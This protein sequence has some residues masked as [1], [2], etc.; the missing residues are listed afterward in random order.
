MLVG[1]LQ[2][3]ETY[4]KKDFSHSKVRWVRCRMLFISHPPPGCWPVCF[5]FRTPLLDAGPYVFFFAGQMRKRIFRIFD[6]SRFFR[7]TP[8][9][10]NLAHQMRKR[11][12]RR[13]DFSRI[14][15]R[16]PYVFYFAH[17]MRKRIFRRFGPCEIEIG[18]IAKSKSVTVRIPAPVMRDFMS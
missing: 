15:C 1:V 16:A 14:F 3:S 4:A 2:G 6:F 18:C 7:R 10:F 8:Y 5:L 11:I 13:F 12:F 17:Q 9:V